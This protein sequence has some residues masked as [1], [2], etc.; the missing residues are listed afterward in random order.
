MQIETKNKLNFPRDFM[1]GVATSSYQIEGGNSNSDWWQWEKQG[2]TTDESGVTCDYWNRFKDDHDL[3]TDLG[4]NTFR[5]SLEWARIE[6]AEGVFSSGSIHHYREILEDLKKRNI[7]TTVTLW[8]W[9]SPIW[10]QEKYGFHHKKS[11]EIF[12]RYCQK[13]VDELGDL[14]DI[15]VVVNEPMVPLG[16]G[17]FGGVFPP[18][19]KNPF[20][21]FKALNNIARA[22][23][24]IYSAIHAKYPKAQV[25]ISYLYNWYEQSSSSMVN[26]LNR[27]SQWYRI[28]LLG[29]K[30]KGYQD[31]IGIDYYRIGKISFNWRKIKL[32]TKNQ[33]YFGFTIEEDEK[34]PMKWISYPEG[35]YRVLK[36]VQAKYG[37]PIYVLENGL[38]TSGGLEDEGRIKFIQEHLFYVDK[39]I[40]EGVDVRGYFYWSLLDNYEWLYGYKPRFGLVEID[41]QTLE[42]KPR[43]SFYEYKGIIENRKK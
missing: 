13:V 1:W 32:D 24:Q 18:G 39:A 42:R 20:K 43:K 2:K 16:M 36:E 35:I 31:Y 9:T 8:H 10:F 40:Q 34:H 37:L 5:L 27:I 14:I 12:S 28:D 22:Y 7:K 29:N 19:F 4:V 38:P 15:Y 17:F 26:C 23:R 41:Y 33:I 25:G 6:G 30:I 3:L 21:F 11:V